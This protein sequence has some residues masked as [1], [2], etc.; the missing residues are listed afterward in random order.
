MNVASHGAQARDS[1][2]HRW[3]EVGR[4]ARRSGAA[5]FFRISQ[6][7]VGEITVTLGG[8]TAELAYSGTVTNIIPKKRNRPTGTVYVDYAGRILRSNLTPDLERQGFTKDSSTI[9]VN[10]GTSVQSWRTNRQGEALV[11]T[12]FRHAGSVQTR[13]GLFEKRDAGWWCTRPTGPARRHQARRQSQ[14]L[15]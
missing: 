8:G 10:F 4:C 9:Y 2:F 15:R 7:Y 11:F 6:A 3:R 1:C 14:N 13:A 12:S 5:A